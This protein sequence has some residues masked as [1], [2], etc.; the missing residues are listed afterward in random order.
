MLGFARIGAA[1]FAQDGSVRQAANGLGDLFSARECSRC[2]QLLILRVA[3]V[4]GLDFFDHL[5]LPCVGVTVGSG[6]CRGLFIAIGGLGGF[7]AVFGRLRRLFETFFDPPAQFAL[8]DE[9]GRVLM[10]KSVPSGAF[11]TIV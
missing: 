5:L 10:R 9:K 11:G 2:R 8:V 6:R 1:V 4:S 3:V 7:A